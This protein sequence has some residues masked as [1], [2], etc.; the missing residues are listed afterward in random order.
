MVDRSRIGE[1]ADLTANILESYLLVLL[2]AR[3]KPSSFKQLPDD[4][5]ARGRAM[6]A[7]DELT[8][9]ESLNVVNL[10]TASKAYKEG[11][12]LL[13]G[14]DGRFTVDS[15]LASELIADLGALLR[16]PDA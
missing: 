6:L 12:V 16:R 14:P 13:A 8:R 15:M 11:D 10:Q 5:L 3:D 1:I 7:A 4:A 2:T 9:P